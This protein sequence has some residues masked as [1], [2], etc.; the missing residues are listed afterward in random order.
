MNRIKIIL[1]TA[2]LFACVAIDAKTTYIPKYRS[3]IHIADKGDTISVA[4]ILPD[5]ELEDKNGLF[6]IRIGHEVVTENKVKTIKR[7]KRA[8]GWAT[9]SAV[10]SGVSAAFSDNSLQYLIRS[11]NARL[12]SE[13]AGLYS[14]NANAEKNLDIYMWVDNTTDDELVVNDMDRGLIW[15]ILPHQ[16]LKLKLFN[17]DASRLR[18]SDPKN[19]LIRYAVVAAGSSVAKWNV[20]WENDEYWI[21]ESALDGAPATDTV[22]SYYIKINKEDYSESIMTIPA[23]RNFIKEQKNK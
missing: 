11:T 1:L 13:L 3:Y 16:S 8:A 21:V 14:A 19:D 12:T 9:L 5:L 22:V 17:P 18:I 7:A 6:S 15:Y 20:A 4:N 10:M 23:Y 2:A